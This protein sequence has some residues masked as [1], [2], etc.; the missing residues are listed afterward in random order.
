MFWVDDELESN[1]RLD[2]IIS[3]VDAK[4]LPGNLARHRP[5]AVRTSMFSHIVEHECCCVYMHQRI[6]H[7][8]VCEG[9]LFCML[10]L[11]FQKQVIHQ[12]AYADRLVLNKQDLGMTPLSLPVFTS[13]LMKIGV[14]LCCVSWTIS[15]RRANGRAKICIESNKCGSSHPRVYPFPSG[16]RPNSQHQVPPIIFEEISSYTLPTFQQ[17]RS[18]IVSVTQGF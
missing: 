5:E 6:S 3:V 11:R 9:C 13:H 18:T 10:L 1:V 16:C 8:G 14:W 2:G 17:R 12:I 15:A 7:N 4:H